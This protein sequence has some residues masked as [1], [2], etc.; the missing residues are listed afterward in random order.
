MLAFSIDAAIVGVA[1]VVAGIAGGWWFALAVAFVGLPVLSAIF[2]AIAGT[3]PGKSAVGLRVVAGDGG[4]PG[5]RAVLRRELWGRLVLEHGLLL[6][7]GAGALGYGAPLAGRDP[8]HD[9]VAGTRVVDRSRR[10][11]PRSL[12]PARAPRERAG[13]GGLVLGG[14]LPRVAAYLI[15][16]GLVLTVW[17]ALFIP[18]AVFT[19]QIDTSGDEPQIEQGFA[20][21]A[22]AAAQLLFGLYGALALYWRETTV[23]K[24]AVGLAVRRD[25]GTRITLGRALLREVVARQVLLGAAGAFLGGIPALLDALWPTWDRRSQALHDKIASTVVVQAAPRRRPRPLDS[26]PAQ[27]DTDGT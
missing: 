23:G 16:F 22:I 19:G 21:A 6:A 5:L 18:V 4:R 24:H 25:D 7:G 27:P 3:T 20:L 9:T 13:P 26:A 1:A 15:D 2:L 8:W 11:W 14:Y 12:L 10:P 17:G